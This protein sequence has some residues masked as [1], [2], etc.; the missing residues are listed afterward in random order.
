[1]IA[2]PA[3]TM[4]TC[5]APILEATR[6]ATRVTPWSV[7]VSSRAQPCSGERQLEGPG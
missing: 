3:A 5:S 1:M 6:A 7:S 2:T 4:R